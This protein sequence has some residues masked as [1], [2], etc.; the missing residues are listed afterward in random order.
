MGNFADETALLVFRLEEIEIRRKN[1]LSAGCVGIFELIPCS[2]QLFLDSIALDVLGIKREDFRESYT[3]WMD[4]IY[5][6]DKEAVEK[7]LNLALVDSKLKLYHRFRVLKDEKQEWVLGVGGSLLTEIGSVSKF[8]GVF[9][10]EPNQFNNC[11][12]H[13]VPCQ[14]APK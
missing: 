4:R 3:D 12:T 14:F 5:P 9:I 10:S 6:P 2:G 8:C 7:S 13:N 1:S 11:P